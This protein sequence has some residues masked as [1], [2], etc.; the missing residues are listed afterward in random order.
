MVTILSSGANGRSSRKRHTPEKS[1]GSER[2][3]HFVSKC[4]SEAGTG[5]RFQ[6]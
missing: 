1:S 2:F 4:A 6:S 5:S 3:T